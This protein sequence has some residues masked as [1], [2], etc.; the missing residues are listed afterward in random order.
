MLNAQHMVRMQFIVL[1]SSLIQWCNVVGSLVKAS[2]MNC[3][4]MLVATPSR[5]VPFDHTAFG[6][7]H[8]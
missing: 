2:A 1:N 4:A 8:L 6:L 5:L 3:K 7:V